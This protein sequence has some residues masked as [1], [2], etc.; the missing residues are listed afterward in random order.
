MANFPQYANTPRIGLGALSSANT[1]RD[2]T[3]TLA[4]V[5]IAGASGTRID[6]IDIEAT[7][8]TTA[9]MIRL[10]LYDGTLTKLWKEIPVS[11]LTPSGTVAA[12]TYKLAIPEGLILPGGGTPWQLKAGTHNAETFNVI[13]RGGDL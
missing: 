9:G 2:G 8:T 6:V 7:A 4:T 3:G 10:F 12:F 5:I 13:A 11:A 1:N